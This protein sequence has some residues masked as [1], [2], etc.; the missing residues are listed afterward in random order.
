MDTEALNR[1]V[2]DLGGVKTVSAVSFGP[3]D[4]A[5]GEPLLT[6][7]ATAVKD[8]EAPTIKTITVGAKSPDQ[9][10]DGYFARMDGIDATFVL[11]ARLVNDLIAFVNPK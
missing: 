6:I 5:F 2:A 8:G 9:A 10:E 11:P 7:K 3:K 4:P 1:L